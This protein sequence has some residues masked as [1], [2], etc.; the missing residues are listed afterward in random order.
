MMKKKLLSICCL[1][2][3]HCDFLSDNI[4]SI[5]MIDYDNIEIIV[6]DDGS[7]DGSVEKL[8]QIKQEIKLPMTIIA[9][10]NTGNVGKNFNTAIKYAKGEL[11]TFISLDD[12]FNASVVNQ[13]I[14][15]MNSKDDLCFIASAKAVSINNDG[16]ITTEVQPLSLFKEDVSNI[17]L[18]K[19]L[20]LEYHEFGSFYIQGAIFKK[21]LIDAIEGFDE[22]QTGDDIVLRTKLFRYMLDN[23]LNHF[24]I[25]KDNSVFYRLH[26]NNAHKNSIRQVKII[27]EYLDKYWTD[28]KPPKLLKDWLL[29]AISTTDTQK[30]MYF[31]SDNDYISS[32]IE[33]DIELKKILARKNNFLLQ[34]LRK[35]KRNWDGSTD[36][37]YF[38]ILTYKRK[39]KNS[40][41][42]IHITNTHWKDNKRA[43]S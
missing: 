3:K 31:I 5:T 20:E 17:T 1:G 19:L 14:E 16:Y 33:G 29:Y 35:K 38:N 11:I 36:I 9:Q 7:S 28:R 27:S 6:V 37:T 8:N 10:E 42:H 25:I 15:R 39:P 30:V 4:E 21:E 23:Q 13:Q 41:T 32:L 12:V 40:N 43:T 34:F 24:Q 22:D 26:E 2:Y 18:D